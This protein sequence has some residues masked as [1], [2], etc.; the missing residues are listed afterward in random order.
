MRLTTRTNLAMRALMFCAANEGRLVR[1]SEIAS[2]CNVSENHLAQ[3][4]HA[5]GIKGFLSTHRG[6]SGG[7]TLSRPMAE[8]SVGSVF[9]ALE[10]E[11]PFLDCFAGGEND[12]PLRSACR[13]KCVIS[14]ALTEFYA[15]LDRTTIADL[16]ADNDPLRNLLR[17]A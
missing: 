3:V 5:L 13:L 11:V 6:R 1:K 12:C 14:N 8:I 10:S 17:V 7:I 16:V 2:V 9:R 4:I 15:M